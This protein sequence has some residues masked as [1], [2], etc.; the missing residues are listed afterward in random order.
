MTVRERHDLP[1]GFALERLGIG[2]DD[3]RQ[4]RLIAGSAVARLDNK[5]AIAF[6]FAEGAKA[7]ERRLS[8]ADSAA[9]MI[10]RDVSGDP[11][12]QTT[13]DGSMAVRHQFGKTGVTLSG[14]T[15]NIW[16]EVKTSATGSPYRWTSVAVDRTFGRNWLSAGISRLEEKQT[17]LGGRMGAALGGGGS[18]SMF[19]DAEVRHQ[20]GGGWSAGVTARRGWTDFAAGN[21]ESGAY[22]F[23]LSKMGVFGSS[24]RFGFRV[25]QP[26]RIEHGGFAAWLPTSYD[27]STETATNSLTRLSL[28]PSGR[29][30]DGELSYGSSLLDG[31]A[32]F[33][34]N[35]FYR[36]QPGHIATADDDMGGAIRFSLAF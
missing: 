26:L 6:G 21:F 34:G 24:D 36:R 28:A 13:R 17:L 10:A 15:G 23:D 31:K 8:G 30:L 3:A 22:G 27:Y 4:S 12:F 11:G 16:Q 18:T 33:G 1:Q 35:L 32:W 25:A 5:T 9:F 14:E 7:M 19:L 20:F 29:E 2:P